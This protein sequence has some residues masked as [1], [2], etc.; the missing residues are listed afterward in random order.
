[1]RGWVRD[2]HH[3]VGEYLPSYLGVGALLQKSKLQNVN[4]Y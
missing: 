3:P 2:S 1:L 4:P